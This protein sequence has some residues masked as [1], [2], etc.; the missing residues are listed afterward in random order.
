M[1]AL[2]T[3]LH[4]SP[5]PV[6][7]MF[8]WLQ[9]QPLAADGWSVQLDQASTGRIQATRTTPEPATDIRIILDKPDDD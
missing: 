8:S 6:T 2:T 7:A 4:G 9:G 1:N 3:A 5:L